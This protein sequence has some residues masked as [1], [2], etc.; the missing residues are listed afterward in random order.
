MIDGM[1][2]GLNDGSFVGILDESFETIK[3]GKGVGC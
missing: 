2:I 1:S 3:V